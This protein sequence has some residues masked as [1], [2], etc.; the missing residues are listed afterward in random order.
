VHP[1]DVQTCRHLGHRVALVTRQL[2]IGRSASP[3]AS[4]PPASSA[5]AR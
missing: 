5:P 1:S 2:T 3:A 4:S